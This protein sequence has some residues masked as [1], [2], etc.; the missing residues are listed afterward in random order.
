MDVVYEELDEAKAEIE[1]LREQC[2]VKTELSEGLKRANS[3]EA[4]KN[5]EASSRLEKLSQKLEEKDH[6]LADAMKMS[7][8]FKSSLTEKERIIRDLSSRYDKLRFDCNEKLH[9]L[10]EE[11]RALGLSLDEANGKNMD[12]ERTVCALRQELEGIKTVLSVSKNKSLETSKISKEFSDREDGFSKLEDENRRFEDRLKW[13]TEQFSHLQEAHDK[14]KNEFQKSEKEWENDRSGLVGVISGLETNLESQTRI[15]RD[16]EYR[17]QMCNQALA[18]SESKRKT[19]EVQLSESK[20]CFDNICAEYDDARSG[21]ENLSAKRDKDIAT[22]RSC[23]STKEILYKEMEYQFRKLEQEKQEL[24]VSLKELQEAQIHEG[25]FSS[26]SKLQKKLK[27]LESLHKSCEVSLKARESEWTSQMDKLSE[28]LNCCRSELK[29]R[30][31]TLGEL[32]KE[33]QSCDSLMLKLEVMNHEYSLTQLVLKSEFSEAQLRFFDDRSHLNLQNK[34]LQQDILVLVEQIESKKAAIVSV[35]K[36]LEEEREKV[37]S[38]SKRVQVLEELQS[39][40][41]KEVERLKGMLENCQLESQE[42]VALIEGDLKKV[43]DALGRANEELYDKFCEAS[44]IE[45]EL[46]IW[47]S[48]AGKL[49]EILKQN[50]QMRGEMEASL[51]SQT[52]IELTLKQEKESL[53]Q[54]LEGLQL[55]LDEINEEKGKEETLHQIVEE[56]DQRIFDLQQLVASLEQE[57]ETSSNS[58]SSK[59]SQMQKE[60]H[61]LRES[62]EKIKEAEI[63]KEMEIQEK[64][65]MIKELG[66]ELLNSEMKTQEIRDELESKIV[67]IH[68]LQNRLRVADAAIK[69]TIQLSSEKEDVI[70]RMGCLYQRMQQITRE[71]QQLMENW[72]KLV[73]TLS[74]DSQQRRND[75]QENTTPIKFRQTKPEEV[76]HEDQRPPFR[77]INFS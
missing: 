8:D 65:I 25:G 38:L 15:S 23:L 42:H 27:S 45:F 14:L 19:L 49:E 69:N 5:K 53:R 32:K 6:E 58:F 30:D 41:Q 77:P 47:K 40:L 59:L 17:L 48:L 71:D 55:Q 44:E 20:T 31:V 54:Q 36:D 22:L 29:N 34:K 9:N 64:N 35:E 73:K 75:N 70:N 37:S 12:Q 46:M 72:G 62:G 2:R 16:L 24:S 66:K 13:K 74:A 18:H 68:T 57:F 50:K 63:C 33:L 28:E 4:S 76:L 10:E 7:E 1:R 56:K 11:N 43:C 61:I 52:E 51:L 67:E 3:E 21:F 39:P 60:I 26:A